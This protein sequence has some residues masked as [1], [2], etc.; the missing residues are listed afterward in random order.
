MT[1]DMTWEHREE[2]IRRDERAEG[3][4]EGRTEGAR[5]QLEKDKVVIE[6]LTA[7]LQENGISVDEANN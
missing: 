3:R 1:V 6:R 2:I 4:A 5:E 7:L